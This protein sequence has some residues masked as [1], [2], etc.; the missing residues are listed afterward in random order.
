MYIFMGTCSD[1]LK[2]NNVWLYKGH[3]KVFDNEEKAL[4]WFVDITGATKRYAQCFLK[5]C[6]MDFL[7]EV[8]TKYM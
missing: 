8:E 5:K 6:D 4:Q 3:P 7:D 2:V 1:D